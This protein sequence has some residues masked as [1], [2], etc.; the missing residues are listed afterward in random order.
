MVNTD[1]R[2]DA[3]IDHE[4]K[5]QR[6]YKVLR[7]LLLASGLKEELKWRVPFYTFENSN[8]VLM[9]GFETYCAL[10]FVKGALLKDPVGILIQ[11]TENVKADRVVRFTHGEQIEEKLPI[12]KAYIQQAIE[13]KK[14]G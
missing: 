6:E 4:K 10:L 7:I 12:L 5:W 13:V 1:P 14:G 9:H 2:V 8:V 11:Q 3:F